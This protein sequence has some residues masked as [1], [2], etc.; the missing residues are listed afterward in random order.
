MPVLVQVCLIAPLF[1]NLTFV[2]TPKGANRVLCDFSNCNVFLWAEVRE[3]N[4]RVVS[5][6]QLFQCVVEPCCS[7]FCHA[8]LLSSPGLTVCGA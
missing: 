1:E 6:F 8:V 7:V 5:V 2:F 4:V 3:E